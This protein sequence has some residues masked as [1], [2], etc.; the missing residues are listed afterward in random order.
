MATAVRETAQ[1]PNLS[2]KGDCMTIKPRLI[3]STIALCFA[4]GSILGCNHQQEAESPD[5]A[6]EEAGE[7]VDEAADEAGDEMEE[8]ADETEDAFD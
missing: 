1:G 8:A 4:A 6:M 7:E 2:T 3:T 5:G